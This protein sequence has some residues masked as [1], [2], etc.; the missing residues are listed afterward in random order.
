MS[1]KDLLLRGGRVV[2]P[3]SGI[4]AVADVLVVSGRVLKVEPDVDEPAAEVIDCTGRVVCP[5]FV[6]MHVHLREPGQE[7][8]ETIA[9]GTRAAIAGGFTAVAC[10]A[11]TVPPNDCVPVTQAILRIARE[12]GRCHVHPVAAVTVRMEGKEI[13]EFGELKRA[14][15]V[16]LSD[17]GRPLSD[18]AVMRR[19]LEY[20]GMF[21][22]TI[23]DHA[24]DPQ[25]AAGGVMNEGW[26]STRLGLRGIPA[27]AEDLHVA[28]DVMLAELT[29]SAVHV[30]HLSTAGALELV[31]RGKR[32][33]ARVTCEVT[34]H[35]LV[36]DEESVSAFDTNCKMKPPLRTEADVKA[37]M[38]GLRDGTV[39]CIAT[40]HAPHHADEKD[41]PFD[42]AAHGVVG[43][44]TAVP[45]AI[46]R[47]LH[48]EVVDLSRLVELLSWNPARVLGVPG[49]TLAVGAIADITI[50]DVDREVVVDPGRFESKSRN[51]PFTGMRLRGGPTTTI[52]A[53]QVVW[54]SE[55][56]VLPR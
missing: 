52:V 38:K 8:K 49:G 50:L 30:A 25:L 53:G 21:D 18:H 11:N 33:G 37:L 17:D 55:H 12:E 9:S 36:L 3:A 7:Y 6:D 35:H 24:E 42:E 31:R 15:A 1:R 16:A 48:A 39:D 44:E 32:G 26:V 28:R 47:L 20:A 46:D 29:G 5:G 54:T 4:D 23:I 51:T 45:L 19:A 34:P 22:L 56:G 40:D 41:L 27:A 2:D 13:T 14:G 43:L 10:M